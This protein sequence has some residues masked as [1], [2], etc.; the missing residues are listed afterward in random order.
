[1]DVERGAREA[2]LGAA[3]KNNRYGRSGIGSRQYGGGRS[4]GSRGDMYTGEGA[5]YLWELTDDDGIL[6][7]FDDGPSPPLEPWETGFHSTGGFL[8]PATCRCESWSRD[9]T[10][11]SWED[12]GFPR[13]PASM[14]DG[15]P[16]PFGRR[17]PEPGC[18]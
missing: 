10:Q 1:M 16:V 9:S 12:G 11:T 8:A 3:P 7:S 13:T 6:S 2:S 15:S 17:A 5:K 14:R 4:G 18:K